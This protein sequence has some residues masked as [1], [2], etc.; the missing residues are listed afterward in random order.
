[1]YQYRGA[2]CYSYV[3]IRSFSLISQ[4]LMDLREKWREQS[5]KSVKLSLRR[6]YFHKDPRKFEN[7]VHAQSKLSLNSSSEALWSC[8]KWLLFE[9]LSGERA[10]VRN[11]WFPKNHFEVSFSNYSFQGPYFKTSLNCNEFIIVTVALWQS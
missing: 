7:S 6:A 2:P 4:K 8:E 11:S 3:V 5:W 9:E 1:M 10:P